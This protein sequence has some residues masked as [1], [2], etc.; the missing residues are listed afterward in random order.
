VTIQIGDTSPDLQPETIDSSGSFFLKRYY[1]DGLAHASYLIA[2]LESGQAAVVD[3]QRDVEQYIEDTTRLGSTIGSVFLTHL[4]ADFVAG[5]LELRDRVGASIHLG[6]RAAAEYPFVA[7][8]DGETVVLGRVQLVALETPGHSPES[9]SILVYDFEHGE[10]PHAV[11]TGDTLLIGDVGRPDLR[12]TLGWT[13][14]RL[15]SELYDSLHTRLAMLPDATIV[16]PAHGAGSLCARNLSAET[17]S[18]IGAQRVQ[19]HALRTMP[20]ERFVELV[21]SD[22]PDAP[23]YFTYDAVLNSIER[24]TLEQLLERAL[25]PL[26]L[27]QVLAL[28]ARGAQLLD[29][30]DPARFAAGHLRGSV[31]V[32]LDGAYETWCGTVLD[33][34]QPLVVIAGS[35]REV[36]AVKRLG[37]TGL[38]RSPVTWPAG[39]VRPATIC[40]P[41]MA[42]NGLAPTRSRGRSPVQ[43]RRSSSTCATRQSGTK[44]GSS[45][46]CTFRYRD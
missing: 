43:N 37:G 18:T 25:R 34:R 17:V 41:M 5:H 16:Y 39:S 20:R 4:H 9:I 29:T 45:R 3:P 13:A 12:G 36:E 2:D 31:N 11:L 6:A 28:A 22:L 21:I 30:R 26:D 46:R 10:E 40:A 7:M 42:Q 32:A 24:P 33:P 15:A 8:G 38:T 27:Q 44:G 19:N 14:E 35:G 23:P 1:F